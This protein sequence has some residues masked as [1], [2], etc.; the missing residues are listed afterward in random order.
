MEELIV[1]LI[2]ISVIN[3]NNWPYIPL[4]SPQGLF[5]NLVNFYNW[6]L[7]HL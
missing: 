5:G 3:G 2:M 6:N 1:V 4:I 7:L